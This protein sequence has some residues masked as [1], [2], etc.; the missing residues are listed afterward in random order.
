VKTIAVDVPQVG[1]D[2][3]R[4]DLEVRLAEA[5]VKRLELD[6]PYK[7]TKKAIADTLLESTIESVGQR[8]LSLD[9]E[10]GLPRDVEVTIVVAF[11]WSNLRE[12]RVLV[13]RESIRVSGTCTY[14]ATGSSQPA[15][16]APAA[17]EDI[18]PAGTEIIANLAQKIV[19]EMEAK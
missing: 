16:S 12:D 5:L 1:K 15:N 4:R 6:T 19:T 18:F 2:A 17:S 14:S 7:V 3:F 8:A 10:T 11:T 9:P 13:H